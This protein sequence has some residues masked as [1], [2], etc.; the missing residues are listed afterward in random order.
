V[1]LDH[2]PT[3][4]ALPGLPTKCIVTYIASQ[5]STSQLERGGNVG[6]SIESRPGGNGG[7][8][9]FL[10]R[11]SLYLNSTSRLRQLKRF[12]LYSTKSSAVVAKQLSEIPSITWR[13]IQGMEGRE[14]MYIQHAR[15]PP[16]VP[17]FHQNYP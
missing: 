9:Q 12:F 16:P 4:I 3:H 17:F 15:N 1:H 14:N 5:K 2:S 10:A 11:V 8:G 6:N 7:S 13:N